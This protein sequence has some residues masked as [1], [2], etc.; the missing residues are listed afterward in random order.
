M[1][2]GKGP[3]GAEGAV[4][5]NAAAAIYVSGMV[6]TL[7]DALAKALEALY[8]GAGRRALDRLREAYKQASQ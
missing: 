3:A 4:L 8:S 1:L 5:L 7:D 6:S 2:E